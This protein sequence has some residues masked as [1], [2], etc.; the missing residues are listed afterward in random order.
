[1]ALTKSTRSNVPTFYLLILLLLVV[2]VG[3]SWMLL[4]FTNGTPLTQIVQQLSKGEISIIA[5]GK[6]TEVI[7]DPLKRIVYVKDPSR[8][9][10]DDLQAWI[11]Y[12]DGTNQERLQI[13]NFSSVFKH[14][15][16]NLVFYTA[17]NELQQ[18]E[19][20]STFYVYN[21]DTQETTTYQVPIA[22]P[23]PGS[24]TS[25]GLGG[26][27]EIAPDGSAVVVQVAF[28]LDCP[29]PSSG[30]DAQGGSGSCEP[31][32]EPNAKTGHYLFNLVSGELTFLSET[33]FVSRWNTPRKELYFIEFAYQNN[34]LKKVDIETGKISVV[35]ATEEFG[36]GAYPIFRKD[37]IVR[38]TGGT[39][40]GSSDNSYSHLAI[41]T[42]S[43]TEK[44][45]LSTEWADLQPNSVWVLP[46]ESGFVFLR[47]G[48]TKGIFKYD[49]A[50]EK[51]TRVS[52]E[53]S[54]TLFY[55]E[56]SWIDNQTFIIIGKASGEL[57][58]DVNS[59]FSMNVVTGEVKQLG[60][61]DVA[62]FNSP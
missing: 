48:Q 45:I 34:N 38:I 21:L 26:T 60:G 61:G 12:P 30:S 43:A 50:S 13:P 28:E 41:R 44:I 37:M 11:M 42:G 33:G 29:E 4:M 59:L 9:R 36:Y 20:R 23:T 24:I 3:L 2:M 5:P 55:G 14:P 47:T 7:T 22:H 49:F 40:G 17:Y 62:K 57:Y 18:S 32:P 53:S 31:E 8:E 35:D 25:A 19:A 1:M 15:S 46:D 56:L 16:S 10:Y 27:E 51:I 52:P 58:N 6:P 39:D 54:Q